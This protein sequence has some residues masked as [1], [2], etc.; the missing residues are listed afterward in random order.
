MFDSI[1]TTFAIQITLI[2]LLI[3]ASIAAI[4]MGIDNRRFKPQILSMIPN[5][6]QYW[7]YQFPS[8]SDQTQTQ[9]EVKQ[10]QKSPNLLQRQQ[11][12]N[13]SL[14]R[15]NELPPSM[16]SY[17]NRINSKIS[18]N[19]MLLLNNFLIKLFKVIS[20]MKI[21]LKPHSVNRN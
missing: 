13:I 14:N 11:F 16:P 4:W 7:K 3:I 10:F 5:H 20:L 21:Q 6:L 9:E 1:S 8:E 18:T 2:I 17:G 19:F 12:S 15:E